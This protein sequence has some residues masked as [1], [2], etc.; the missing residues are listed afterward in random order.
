MESLQYS[1]LKKETYNLMV[2]KRKDVKQNSH[3]FHVGILR[4]DRSKNEM[5]FQ[6]NTVCRQH[7]T[8]RKNDL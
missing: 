1:S 2:C 6:P 3:D 5:A 8:E 4:V 7:I